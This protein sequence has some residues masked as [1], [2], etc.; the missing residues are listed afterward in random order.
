[1]KFEEDIQ[2]QIE[3]GKQPQ[4]VDETAYVH[5][6]NAL[7]KAP[8]E[9]SAAGVADRVLLRLEKR[10]Q[11]TRSWIEWAWSIFGGLLLLTGLGATVVLTNFKPDFGF[12]SAMRDYAGLVV[13][14]VV[15]IIALNVL[16]RQ[17]V[18]KRILNS[19][20]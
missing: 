7:K 9:I 4:N 3:G 8:A 18:R 6:F 2:Q 10:S 12:L 19:R 11:S 15:F 5:V 1:M 14:G 20:I 13:F 16:D 17:L